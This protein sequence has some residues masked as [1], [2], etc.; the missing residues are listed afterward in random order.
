MYNKA[1]FR[2]DI[3]VTTMPHKCTERGK[4]TKSYGGYTRRRQL[5]SVRVAIAKQ[6][7]ALM[8]LELVVAVCETFFRGV[9]PPT[10]C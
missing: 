3:T 2:Y 4:L 1:V 5:A 9:C 10:V 8:C 6:L 7:G